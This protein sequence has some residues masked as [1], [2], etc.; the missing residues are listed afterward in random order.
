MGVLSNKFLQKNKQFEVAFELG[1]LDG[2]G[3]DQDFCS[4]ISFQ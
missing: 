1:T 4:I 3:L 2:C